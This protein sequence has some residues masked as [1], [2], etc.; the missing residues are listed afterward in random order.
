MGFSVGKVFKPIE[1]KMAEYA[2]VDS[3]ELPVA[4][5]SFKG[6]WKN[7][8]FMRKHLKKNSYDA[9]LITGTENYLLP[10]IHSAKKVVVVH[11]VKS[12]FNHV[13]GIRRK[14]KELMF[15]KVLK[16]ADKV[17][18]ISDQTRQELDEYNYHSDV[19]Y[20][21][22]SPMFTYVAK[23][24]NREKPIVL[25]IGTK[26]NKN[27]KNTILALNGLKCHLRIVGEI[28]DEEINRLHKHNV[29]FSSCANISD[30]ELLEEYRKCDIVN[31]PSLYEGFGMPIIEGQATGRVVVTS[32]L[33]PMKDVAGGIAILVNP[34]DIHS[35]HDGYLEAINNNEKYILTGLENVKRFSVA[36]ITGQYFNLIK[37]LI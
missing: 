16:Y 20:D 32:N 29:E 25:H 30:E 19:I 8:S 10:F 35:M 26:P 33:S 23:D 34:N 3:I 15:I 31:F 37:S 36:T 6:L 2:E 7:V 17:V 24:F 27:L 22:V 11:D 18:A 13:S 14:L 4:N 9:I 21:P 28:S 5:Y 12:F 1:K